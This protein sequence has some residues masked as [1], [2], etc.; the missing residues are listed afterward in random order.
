MSLVAYGS[1]DESSDEEVNSDVAETQRAVNET[2]SSL[3]NA[4]ESTNVEKTVKP[5]SHMSLPVPRYKQSSVEVDD[6]EGTNCPE[7]NKHRVEFGALPKPK[8]SIYPVEEIVEDDDIPLFQ[9]KQ[10]VSEK[11]VKQDRTPVRISV[12]SL[13]DVRTT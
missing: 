2:S 3:T 6:N 5:K 8:S 11:I 12:P 9:P 7:G 4:K 13:S 1:S 10:F